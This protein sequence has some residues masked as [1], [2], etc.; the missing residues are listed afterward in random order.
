MEALVAAR[1][2]GRPAQSP[3]LPAFLGGRP[4]SAALPAHRQIHRRPRPHQGT[5]RH[6]RAAVLRRGHRPGRDGRHEEGH[7]RPL[8][9]FLQGIHAR[10]GEGRLRRAAE[11][12]RP[13]TTS[14]SGINDDVTHTSL[15]YD[16]EFSTEVRRH[17][18]RAVLRPGR[19]WH[20]GRQ[21]ELHQDHRRGD[22]QLTPRATSS[23]IPRS[24]APSPLPT[25]ASD[26]SRCTPAT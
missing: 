17:R 20:R 25:C 2:E 13:K 4:S 14:P 24:P 26:P 16:P 11:A 15:D 10:H 18:A 6:R 7:R 21:Q 1:R 9:P 3:P 12:V 5:G 19:R 23:T 22:R 8:R